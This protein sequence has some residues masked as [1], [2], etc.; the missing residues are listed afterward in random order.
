MDS[1]TQRLA[2]DHAHAKLLG[3]LL[4]AIDG[5]SVETE[6]IQINMVFFKVDR[7]KRTPEDFL[8]QLKEK[9]ILTESWMITDCSAL[10]HIMVSWKAMSGLRRRQSGKSWRD[11]MTKLKAVMFDMDGVLIDSERLSLSMWEKVNEARGHVFDVSVMTNMMGGSQQENFERFGHLLPPMEV[12]EAMWQ[13]KKQMT[14][15][16][17]EANGMPLRPG[18]K[19]ILASLKEMGYGG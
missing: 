18:V 6:R 9:G 8:N 17:I 5:I 12:Y 16:W 7:E 4:A 13:E 3:S 11:R 2:E 14:D 10:S 1:M 19:E 15:A